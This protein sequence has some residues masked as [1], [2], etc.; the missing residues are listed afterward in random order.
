MTNG[1]CSNCAMCGSPLRADQ[2]FCPVCGA[3]APQTPS[4]PAAAFAPQS[5]AARAGQA[6]AVASRAY[7]AI[8]QLAGL[9]GMGLA[10]PWQRVAGAGQPNIGAF[11]SAA[12]LPGAQRAIRASLKRPGAALAVTTVFS[13]AVAMITGGTGALSLYKAIPQFVLG[14]FTSLLSLATGSK[15]GRIRKT[16]GIFG[17]VTA[18]AQLGFAAYTLISGAH[19]GISAWVIVPQVVAMAS[20]LVMAIKTSVVAFRR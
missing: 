15:G 2:A 16:T 7:G 5:P 8:G 13:L 4:V 3:I 17:A 9:A 1:Y 12:A 10:P 14:G 6:A 18:V 19:D 20:S 11:L